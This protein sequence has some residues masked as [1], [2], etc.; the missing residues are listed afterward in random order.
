[1]P[2]AFQPVVLAIC[3]DSSRRGG[4]RAFTL[5]E[6]IVTCLL[7]GILFTVMVPL[8]ATTARQ[9]QSSDRRLAAITH[10]ANVLERWIARDYADLAGGTTESVPLPD[11]MAQ[12]LPRG[13][14]DVSVADESQGP[15][16]RRIAV[17]VQWQDRHGP[18]R[19]VRITGWVFRTG[20]RP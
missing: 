7:L 19:P 4:R 6:L 16:A 1:M 14:V 13:A 20:G 5:L 3:R 15:A 18:A 8:L 10:A 2:S 12:L 11:D 9:R 17:T